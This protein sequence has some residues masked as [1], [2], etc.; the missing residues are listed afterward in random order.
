MFTTLFAFSIIA[1]TT[2]CYFLVI[3]QPPCKQSHWT[4]SQLIQQFIVRKFGAWKIQAF[5][6]HNIT[7]LPLRCKRFNHQFVTIKNHN[8]KINSL[9][10]LPLVSFTVALLFPLLWIKF[11]SKSKYI[12][13]AERKNIFIR[14]SNAFQ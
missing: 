2:Q 5:V 6:V 9:F 1:K 12:I 14:F 11:R 10:L 7:I 3:A 13:L 8:W 4:H